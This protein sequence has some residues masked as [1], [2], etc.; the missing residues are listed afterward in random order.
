VSGYA[1]APLVTDLT[2]LPASLASSSSLSLSG[3]L[4]RH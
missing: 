2:H 4:A 1:P 3:D